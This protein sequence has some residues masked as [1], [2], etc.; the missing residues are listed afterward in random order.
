MKTMMQ[1]ASLWGSL[2]LCIDEITANNREI[3][4]EWI[5]RFVFDYAAGMHKIKGTASGNTEI[6]H[7]A[8]W[9]GLA[10]LTSN[11]PSLEAMMGARKHTSEGEARRILEWELPKGKLEWTASER[12]ILRKLETNYGHAGRKYAQWCVLN[13]EVV[14][15]KLAEV[16]DRWRAV[17]GCTD[18]ERF[19]SAAIVCDITGYILAGRN[20]ANVVDI[21]VKEIVEFWLKIVKRQR[22]IIA[23][24]QNTAIDVLNA[25]TREHNGHFVMAEAGVV[26]QHLGGKY[27]IQPNTARTIVRGRVEFNVVPG[28]MDHYIEEKML[29]M[30]CAEIGVGY[31]TFLSELENA[32]TVRLQIKNLLMGTKGPSLRVTCVKI[33]RPIAAMDKE[34]AADAE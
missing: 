10:V 14:Q 7:D 27:A 31:E 5:P 12:E 22:K 8:I 15:K 26:M 6:Q 32:A 3:N 1:R 29:R 33:T 13:K 4:R 28:Y 21:P 17:S 30:H 19:W 34:D 2:P 11:T 23:G 9:S 25:Y 16:A 18:D 20:Y 24:N